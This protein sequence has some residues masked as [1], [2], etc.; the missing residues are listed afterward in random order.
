MEEM[1]FTAGQLH[2]ATAITANAHKGE[3]LPNISNFGGHLKLI[4]QCFL[5]T[6]TNT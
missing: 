3:T 1:L 5:E 6:F 2:P 4:V